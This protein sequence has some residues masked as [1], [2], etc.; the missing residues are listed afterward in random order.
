MAESHRSTRSLAKAPLLVRWTK[1]YVAGKVN[2]ASKWRGEFVFAA[3][4]WSLL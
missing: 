2:H 3:D 1:D 4:G